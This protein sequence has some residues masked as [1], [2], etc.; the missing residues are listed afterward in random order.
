VLG[1][2]PGVKK[3]IHRQSGLARPTR[4]WICPV[5]APCVRSVT[6]R[7]TWGKKAQPIQ[8]RTRGMEGAAR[9]RMA[10]S[11]RTFLCFSHLRWNFVLERPQQLLT[12]CARHNKVYYLEEPPVQVPAEVTCNHS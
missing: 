11:R 8:P 2:P 1:R 9:I 10:T 5:F 6:R 12:R 4:V 3:V 7:S